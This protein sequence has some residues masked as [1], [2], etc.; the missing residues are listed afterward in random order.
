MNVVAANTTPGPIEVGFPDY[1]SSVSKIAD[2]GT[3]LR[4]RVVTRP[5][6]STCIEGHDIDIIYCSPNTEHF[7]TFLRTDSAVRCAEAVKSYLVFAEQWKGKLDSHPT[8]VASR[9]LHVDEHQERF[10]QD[11]VILKTLSKEL[12]LSCFLASESLTGQ[13]EFEGLR[14]AELKY[15]LILQY[16]AALEEFLSAEKFMTTEIYADPFGGLVLDFI[17]EAERITLILSDSQLQ[18]LTYIGGH[19]D[20]AI[21][22]HPK[23]AQIRTQRFL[24]K[25]LGKD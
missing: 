13:L 6:M 14:N 8:A 4:K 16:R 19:F 9:P 1:V 2:L 18:V 7:K 22:K 17:R 3:V 15:P 20:E 25:A 5:F 23:T 10:E 11:E 12:I 21:F 24:E